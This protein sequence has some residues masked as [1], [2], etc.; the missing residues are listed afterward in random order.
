MRS[1]GLP[2]EGGALRAFSYG[3]GAGVQIVIGIFLIRR[4]G[5]IVEW[6]FRSE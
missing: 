5:K 4:S 1:F 3:L 6:L 2:A